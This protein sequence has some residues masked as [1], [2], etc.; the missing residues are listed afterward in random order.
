MLEQSGVE[1]VAKGE[2]VASDG[3]EVGGASTEQEE[4]SITSLKS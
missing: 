3:P 1:D 2:F 4:G